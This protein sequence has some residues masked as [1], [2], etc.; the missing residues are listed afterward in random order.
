MVALA[1]LG[2]IVGTVALLVVNSV[3]NG[4]VLNVL[5]G[6]FMVPVFHLPQLSI[7]PAIGIAIVVGY[8]TYQA[9]PDCQKVKRTMGQTIALATANAIERPLFA[10]FFGYVVHLFM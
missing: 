6:W 9:K 1:V 3:F 2:G 5:W 10:L 8:L 4:Y 7:V